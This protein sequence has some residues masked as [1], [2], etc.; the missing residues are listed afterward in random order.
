MLVKSTGL[1]ERV[2]GILAEGFCSVEII[3]AGDYLIVYFPVKAETFVVGSHAP[4]FYSLRTHRFHAI[5]IGV[6]TLRDMQD[7][8]LPSRNRWTFRKARWWDSTIEFGRRII[9]RK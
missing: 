9:K 7:S 5:W 8:P 1:T 2:N 4:I 3:R 6:A